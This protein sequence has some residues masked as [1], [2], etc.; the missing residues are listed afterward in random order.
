M[1]TL[2]DCTVAPEFRSEYRVGAFVHFPDLVSLTINGSPGIIHC[3][4][5]FPKLKSYSHAHEDWSYRGRSVLD[6]ICRH[7]L[8]N[9]ITLHNLIGISSA[10]FPAIAKNI[11]D[12]KK[13]VFKSGFYNQVFGRTSDYD[14]LKNA[15]PNMVF[16]N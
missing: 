16:E 6:F 11:W 1:L 12:L 13:F 5:F 4:N 2:K 10:I 9:E 14:C 7:P 3:D 8:L 15:F